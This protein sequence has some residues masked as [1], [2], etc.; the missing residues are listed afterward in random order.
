MD[1]S[2][3]E[4]PISDPFLTLETNL[5]DI[6]DVIRFDAQENMARETLSW[7]SHQ[8]SDQNSCQFESKNR[9]NQHTPPQDNHDMFRF[10][11]PNFDSS[12]PNMNG[13]AGMLPKLE[14]SVVP[15][16]HPHHHYLASITNQQLTTPSMRPIS[17]VLSP[18]AMFIETKPAPCLHTPKSS[19]HIISAD[20]SY[21]PRVITSIPMKVESSMPFRTSQA[22]SG[23]GI[24]DLISP[25]QSSTSGS[26]TKEELLRLLV[27]MSPGQVEQL[28]G[29]RT[30]ICRHRAAT[31][32]ARAHRSAE[33]WP[34][35]D[36]SDDEDEDVTVNEPRRKGP[37]SHRR[38]AHNLIE[39]KYRCSINDRIQ[40]LKTILGG[41][42]VKLSKSAILKRAIDHI[43]KLESDNRQLRFEVHHLTTILRNHNIEVLPPSPAM[44]GSPQL[45]PSTSST[46]AHSPGVVTS[47]TISPT[48]PVKG[49]K[50]PRTNMEQ[51]RVTIFAIMF[52]VLLWNPLSLLSSGSAVEVDHDNDDMAPTGG[53]VLIER[54]KV[55]NN[56]LTT[57]E[58]WQT[59]VIRPC[60]VWSVNIF[61]VVCVLT[62]LLVYGEPV[63]DF[64]SCTWRTFLSIRNIAREE[65]DKGN[66]RKAQRL[67]IE[68]LQIL[69][70]P[71]PLAGV[72]Q[73]LS[74]VWQI[75][76]HTLNS[77]WIGRWFSR[78]RRDAGKPVTVVCKC[79]A[80]TAMIYH[81]MHQL[82]LL[83][84]DE[85]SEGVSG[86]YLALSAVNL[87]E[88][89]G[90][91]TDGLPRNVLADIYIAA[92]IRTRLCLPP[93]LA[94]IFSPY[95]F[96]RARRHV[97]RADEESVNGLHW[98][99]HPLSRN[100]LADTDTMQTILSGKKSSFVPIIGDCDDNVLARLS[101]MFKIRLLT[102]LANEINEENG[103]TEI[104]VVD[105]ISRLLVSMSTA[106]KPKKGDN[107]DCATSLADGDALC[108][109]W[110]H[111]L[112]CAVF[113]K[114]GLLE[115]A[116]QHYTIVRRCPDELLSN[117][118]ALAVGHA[119]CCRKLCLDNKN[120]VNFGNYVSVHSRKA[121]EQLKTICI[122]A[123]APEVRQLHEYLRCLAYEWVMSSLLEAWRHDLVPQIPY[124]NQDTKADYG[125][126]YEEACDHYTHI[127]LHSGCQRGSRLAAYQLTSRM[128]NGA[129]PLHTWA[130]VC[131]IRKERFDAVDGR[132]TYNAQ[133]PDP[134]H[135]QVLCRMHDNLP[136]ICE[137][138]K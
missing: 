110:T 128:L 57:N 92:A 89:A 52:A 105:D 13:P 40:H 32:A 14:H 132:F 83:G 131:C 53:R 23:C 98:V 86:F 130:A 106:G 76:R 7:G 95:F 88:S 85:T 50:R 28:K 5:E 19:G 124:W 35:D 127:Q 104:N 25:S 97:R 102:L 91:S 77:L 135:L 117:S 20:G 100:F 58:W 49:V 68:C 34:Q 47:P 54:E 123:A 17:P 134:F 45:S 101:V 80:H 114:R 66:V 42:D 79:H 126:I 51:G 116:K 119:F 30:S 18:P 74:V 136:R 138:I 133:Q 41:N 99:F 108:T 109:W 39:K 37:T 118:L 56:Y 63:Q 2:F 12:P 29:K 43:E 75:I 122:H 107:W 73:A 64:K 21:S 59:K 70:R 11:P 67:Y 1:F 72:E 61:I 62:R 71:L 8:H 16:L 82:H 36:D 46:S 38:T 31:V 121:L 3:G 24:P 120:N 113:W 55:F 9:L 10:S 125:T 103:S 48:L 90:A 93:F 87:A 96:K 65:A 111:V 33:G 137:R 6:N 115:K 129:N 112:T 94:S 78:R 15:P 81:K 44:M 69:E 22:P 26:T 27:N 84:I 4:I 60:F